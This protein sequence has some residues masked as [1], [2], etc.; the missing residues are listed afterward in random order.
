MQKLIEVTTALGVNTELLTNLVLQYQSQ[1][2]LPN[3]SY[4]R[5]Y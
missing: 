3:Y 4:M 5:F 2:I 1:L